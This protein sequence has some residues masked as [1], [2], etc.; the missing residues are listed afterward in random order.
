MTR[1]EHKVKMGMALTELASAVKEAERAFIR[2]EQA[3]ANYETTLD[4]LL[5][6][7]PVQEPSK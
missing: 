5:S 7:V 4:A 1:H 2:R 3:I 6:D